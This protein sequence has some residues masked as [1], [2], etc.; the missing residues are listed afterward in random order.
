MIKKRI[1]TMMLSLF[2][3]ACMFPTVALAAEPTGN[4]VAEING[5]KY[6]T[7]KAAVEKAKEGDTITL[8]SDVT[9]DV[10]FNKN[11]TVDGAG[12]YTISGL[13]TVQAG[14]L[15]NL[16]LKPNDNNANGNLLTIGSGTE[17]SINLEN[18][19]IHY[20]ATKRSGGSA[21]TVSGNKAAIKIN[22]CRFINTPNNNE[23][24]I[25]APEW[26]YGL[27]VNEQNDTGSITFTNNEFNGAFRTMLPNVSG[28]FLIEN[29]RF[30]NSVYS[31]KD[32]P[33]GGAG[34]E[35]TTITTSSATNNQIV[36]KNNTF[37]NAGAIYLQTQANFTGNTIKNDKFEHYIQAKGGIG[38]PID[39]TKNTF[40][41]G[42][43]NLVIIDVAVTPVLLPAGQPAVNYW[44]WADTP[45]DVRPA[46][47]SDYKYMYNKDGSIT[48]MPQSN[49]ALEQFFNQNKG[50]IQVDN[51]DTVLVEENLELGNITID[52]SK[53]ITF[54]IAEGST[55]EIT[56][57]LDIQGKVTI[58]GEGKLIIPEQGNVNIDPDAAL[59][60]APNAKFENN[61]K[62]SN[63]GELT[64]PDTSTGSGTIEGTGT[65]EKA[66]NAKHFESKAPTCDADGN[67]E[68]WYCESCDKY[69]SDKDLTQEISKENII[70]KALGH[71]YKNGK[72]TACGKADPSYKPNAPQTNDENH[73]NSNQKPSNSTVPKTGDTNHIGLLA[74][75]MLLSIFSFFTIN[76][77]KRKMN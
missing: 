59:D 45:E 60:V 63:N 68:Y 14:T 77:Y 69:F 46:D 71:K 55:L 11:I 56:G 27:F 19:T 62:I 57:T 38:Q 25:D 8:L 61:G 35:A 64:I 1:L 21:A 10:K 7:L 66:H 26:S 36:V 9:E 44:I 31:V 48:F 72:C 58:K 70:L 74:A 50:N 73:G 76:I 67:I 37:D 17:T 29:C 23:V 54:E 39:F 40:Q 33:T 43:N 52:N 20:S 42:T 53:N 49:V 51:H 5:T 4:N 16:T 22:N 34:S 32:G 13:S 6:E 24:T 75:L 47:Y 2:V 3:A 65:T 12:K 15:T 28:N 30:I 41:L 18:V